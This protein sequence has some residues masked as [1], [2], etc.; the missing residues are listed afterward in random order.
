VSA[1]R[2]FDVYRGSQIGEGKKSMAYCLTY[3][4]PDKTLTDAEAAQIRNRI[5]KRLAQEVGAK[6]RS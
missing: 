3:Q 4:A 2:L 1:V 5:V 6:L